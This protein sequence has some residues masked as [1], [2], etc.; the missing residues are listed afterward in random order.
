[1][2]P[3]RWTARPA[4]TAALLVLLVLGD[5][6]PA[7]AASGTA[8]PAP[9]EVAKETAADSFP[10]SLKQAGRDF[11]GDTG[12]IWTSPARI[13]NR[14]VFPLIAL[15][16]GT[17]F[18]IAGDEAIRDGVQSYADQHAWVGE[19]APVV[20]QLGGVAGFAAAGAFFG[21]GLLFRDDRAR[22]TGYL[23][24][25]AILQAMLVD[26][27]LKIVAGRQRPY[28]ADGEDHWGGPAAYF[29]GSGEDNRAFPSGHAAT[30]FAL[31][32]VVSMQYGR[33]AWVPV[34]AYTLA[35]GAGLSRMALDKHWSSDVLVG[36]VVGHLVARLVVRD[37]ARRR[38]FTPMLACSR[39]GF[40]VSLFYD[41]GPA[42]R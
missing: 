34:V 23:A 6:V 17:T 25:S 27:V 12:R 10:K 37:Y 22:D 21:A 19:V 3:I 26:N 32:T 42:G 16:A 36:A 8:G 29:K 39:R 24:A 18:L 11:L 20:T 13:R 5:V 14:D 40:A 28:V 7:I 33:R 9:A 41:L 38:R 2:N 35:A 15:A 4:G 1:M 30:A 31:A